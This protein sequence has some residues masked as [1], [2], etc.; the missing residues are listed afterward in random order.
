MLAYFEG[1][2]R[3]L[4]ATTEEELGRGRWTRRSATFDGDLEITLSLPFLLDPPSPSE[5]AQHGFVDRRSMESLSTQIGRFVDSKE[6]SGIDEIN[7]AVQAEF[8]NRPREDVVSYPPRTPLEEAQDLCFE[9]F[10]SI[11]YRRVVLARRAIEISRDYADAYVLLAEASGSPQEQSTLYASGVEAGRRALGDRF[12]TDPPEHAWG[13]V[14]ARPAMRAMLGLAHAQAELGQIDEAIANY[15][16]LLRI[17]PDD[18]QGIR[19]LLLPMLVVSDH[20]SE[21]NE[22]IAEYADE[23]ALWL[24]A[25]AL[26]AFRAE[27][28]ATGPRTI[29]RR[30]IR[31]APHIAE[32]LLGADTI[33][34]LVS[35]QEEEDAFFFADVLAPAWSATTGAMHWLESQRDAVRS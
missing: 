13:R 24:Y 23:E 1:I 35:R 28:D 21:A 9:A 3:A 7:E 11:G 22:L 4:A 33:D 20:D 12:F 15:R 10:D 6:F 16:E 19:F 32:L 30:A 5:L 29:V 17:N 2:L 25:R 26:L 8:V 34:V 18:N 27:G 31:Q 14:D